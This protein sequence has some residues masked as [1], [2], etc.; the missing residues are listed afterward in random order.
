MTRATGRQL[1]AL[2]RVTLC[3]VTAL[4]AGCGTEPSPEILGATFRIDTADV[5]GTADG[6]RFDFT[7]QP[8]EGESP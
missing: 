3:A 8:A 4:L 7:P 5:L 1:C 2:N 6:R